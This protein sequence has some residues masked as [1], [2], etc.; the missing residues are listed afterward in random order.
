MAIKKWFLTNQGT[1]V[2]SQWN[3]KNESGQNVYVRYRFGRLRVHLNNDLIN[4]LLELSYGDF[5][6]GDMTDQ[7]LAT[8]LKK[9]LEVEI[10]FD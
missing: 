6:D 4:H 1:M 3:G 10:E 5:G 7:E 8:L 9:H 2:P